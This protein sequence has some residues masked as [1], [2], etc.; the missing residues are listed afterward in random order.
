MP[1]VKKQPAP[2]ETIGPVNET[3]SRGDQVLVKQGEDYYVVSSVSA[4][5]TGF[6]TLVFRSDAEGN[7]TDWGEVAGGRGV[8]RAE[9][10][11]QLET[12]GAS[13][14]DYDDEDE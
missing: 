11:G 5:F 2:V 7:I 12:E 1:E 9:A 8:S 13:W 10:I 3:E 6:E 14:W 4:P